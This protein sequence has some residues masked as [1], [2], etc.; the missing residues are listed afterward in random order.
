MNQEIKNTI[1][2]FIEFKKT[3][4]SAILGIAESQMSFADVM[5]S[6]QKI[7]NWHKK[8][9]RNLASPDFMDLK[10]LKE[11][12]ERLER[13]FE[14]IPELDDI[15]MI[16]PERV[17]WSENLTVEQQDEIRNYIHENHKIVIRIR[18]DRRLLKKK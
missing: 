17:I 10:N 3:R 5:G 8:V 2:K 16:Q 15:F 13:L 7:L 1:D 4:D 12:R 14:L 11:F 9:F 6:V 18:R